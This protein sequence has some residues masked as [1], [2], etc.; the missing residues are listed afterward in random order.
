MPPGSTFPPQ[1]RVLGGGCLGLA[2]CKKP[3]L[4]PFFAL[5]VGLLT[6]LTAFRSEYL[7]GDP[8]T[9]RGRGRIGAGS[10]GVNRRGGTDVW[11][12]PWEASSAGS[13]ASMRACKGACASAWCRSAVRVVGNGD[14]RARR[15]RWRSCRRAGR[16]SCSSRWK[17]ERYDYVLDWVD[18]RFVLVSRK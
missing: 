7:L 2:M 16:C 10:A 9:G 4:W 3:V 15:R 17:R 11:R 8:G 5:S 18:N 12:R 13:P 1:A 6:G 14:T